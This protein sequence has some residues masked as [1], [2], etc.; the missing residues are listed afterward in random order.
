[1][2]EKKILLVG[3]RTSA[4]LPLIRNK[5]KITKVIATKDSRLSEFAK[6]NRLQ[7]VETT[8]R[9]QFLNELDNTDY[10]LMISAGCP[11]IIPGSHLNESKTYLNLHPSLLPFYPGKHAITEAI[12][13][14]GPYGVTL[15]QM[16]HKVDSGLMILQRR[17]LVKKYL[18]SLAIHELFFREEEKLFERYLE[19]N[20]DLIPSSS[21][22]YRTLISPEPEFVRDNNFRN[23]TGV[24]SPREIRRRVKALSCPGHYA[25]VTVS[26]EKIVEIKKV[27]GPWSR[28]WFWIFR[29]S[30][31]FLRIPSKF[32]HIFGV[33]THKN[34]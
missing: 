11:Y 31:E 21:S 4:A 7:L 5:V 26:E 13:R 25:F 9:A 12:Y 28:A 16:A 1:M 10:N 34:H 22:N 15:H 2:S 14:G 18:N 17:I 20:P 27:I 29:P 30:Q 19:S 24:E 8:S 6:N 32:S 23:L 33:P 3:N